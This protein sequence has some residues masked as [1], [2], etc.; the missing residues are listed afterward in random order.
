[1]APRTYRTR[2]WLRM[3]MLVAAAF[4]AAV[5]LAL[6]RFPGVPGESVLSATAFLVFF[7]AFGAHYERMAIEV[8]P[9]GLV[10][11]SF[12]RRVPV[13]WD[14]ILRVEVHTGLAGTLYAV[15]T[16]RGPVQFTSLWA[17]HRELFG[18]LLER[19]G[20]ARAR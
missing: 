10:F 4:W 5:L 20:L 12:F 7:A 18:I 11:R 3:A 2:L 19:A 9:D 13:R 17:R 15:L 16:R 14:D 1:V 8:G 6:A